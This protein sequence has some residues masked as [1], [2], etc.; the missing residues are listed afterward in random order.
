MKDSLVECRQDISRSNAGEAVVDED[1]D[2][3]DSNGSGDGV[4]FS[5][6]ATSL[7]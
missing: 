1:D 4:F 6:Y 2:D 3:S 7:S 5:V